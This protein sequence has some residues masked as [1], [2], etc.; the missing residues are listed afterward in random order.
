MLAEKEERRAAPRYWCGGAG[1]V[2][3]RRGWSAWWSA[4]GEAVKLFASR[5]SSK[6]REKRRQ[7]DGK[8]SSEV[9]EKREDSREIFEWER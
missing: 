8:E 3:R 9:E 1:G 4:D 5:A 6:Q 2:A 7:K